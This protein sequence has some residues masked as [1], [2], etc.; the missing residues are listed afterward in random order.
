MPSDET[1]RV[2]LVCTLPLLHFSPS[3]VAVAHFRRCRSATTWSVLSSS[4]APAF[5]RTVST[6]VAASL[7]PSYPCASHRY[8]SFSSRCLDSPF[9]DFQWALGDSL[10]CSQPLRPFSKAFATRPAHPKLRI[11]S[12][13]RC[14]FRRRFIPSLSGS[15]L[16]TPSRAF[17]SS[18]PT[19]SRLDPYGS[20]VGCR[21]CLA[22]WQ[23]SRLSFGLESS[24]VLFFH[25]T[26]IGCRGLTSSLLHGPCVPCPRDEDLHSSPAC[27]V[28]CTCQFL[29]SWLRASS[30]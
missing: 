13:Q 24:P 21:P 8:D 6:H 10:V 2:T 23:D 27:L 9:L 1:L 22:R 7:G 19:S 12:Y 5:Q 26:H 11:P 3:L 4:S 16:S 17:P 30:G 29:S 28:T 15:P 20:R 14:L 18:F 25:N